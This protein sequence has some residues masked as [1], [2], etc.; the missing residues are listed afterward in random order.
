M[1]DKN[2]KGR[3]VKELI[4]W[5]K[6]L[7]K[8]TDERVRRNA[9]KVG[10]TLRRLYKEK[11][12]SNPKGMLGKENK[13]GHHSD[14]TKKILSDKSKGQRRSPKTE[15][16]KGDVPWNENKKTGIIP[17]NKLFF[18][19]KQKQKIIELFDKELKSVQEVGK[20]FGCT[21]RP[22]YRILKEKGIEINHAKRMRKKYSGENSFSYKKLNEKKIIELYEEGMSSEKIGKLMNVDGGTI[23]VRLRKNG[24]KINKV[25]FGNKKRL[26]T[27]DGHKV[28][29]YPELLI[30]NFF[31]HNK[32]QHIY[33][34]KIADTRY[35]YD[36]YLPESNLYIEYWGLECVESY[37]EKTKRKLEIYN[38]LGLKLLSIFP[39]DNI[40]HK[41]FPLLEFSKNQ[42]N[43]KEL[44]II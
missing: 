19:E 30:D 38:K 20:I 21:D 36:F 5:N 44:R 2:K 1:E 43:L 15:F 34:Q 13:W 23:I 22:I 25:A 28:R 16:K 24:I 42:T 29:S 26:I 8:E 35:E 40:H 7:T 39:K 37:K 27:D 10:K 18:T 12:I 31:F 6:G 32:I 3:F 4:P 11:K 33:G 9:E 17:K 14:K 41:L